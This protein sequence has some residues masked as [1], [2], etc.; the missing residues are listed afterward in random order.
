MEV[1]SGP[2][3]IEDPVFS[4]DGRLEVVIVPAD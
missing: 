4:E 1:R 2:G 3:N